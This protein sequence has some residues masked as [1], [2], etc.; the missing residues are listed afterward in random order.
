[1]KNSMKTIK[2]TNID[3]NIKNALKPTA[4]SNLQYGH[5][6]LF[7]TQLDAHYFAGRTVVKLLATTIYT[8]AKTDNDI[9][10]K[11]IDERLYLVQSGSKLHEEVC[12][13]LKQN[14][15]KYVYEITEAVNEQGFDNVLNF[16]N[17]ARNELL[18]LEQAEQEEQESEEMEK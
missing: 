1:M 9:E 7:H 6:Y 17:N 12:N 14:P 2:G 10:G 11:D 13:I 15:N 4:A 3:I 5:Y 18:Q 8:Y 16:L